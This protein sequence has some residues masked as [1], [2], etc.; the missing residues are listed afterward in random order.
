MSE[1]KWIKLSTGMFDDEKIRF[2]ETLPEADSILVIWLKLLVLAGKKNSRGEIFMSEDIPYT[3]ELLSTIFHRKINTVRLALETFSRLRMIE[4]EADK[5]IVISNW[6]K[7]QNVDGLEKIRLANAERV[8]RHR[9]KKLIGD[10]CNVTGNVTGHYNVTPPAVTVTRQK[11]KETREEEKKMERLSLPSQNS[12]SEESNGIHE[13]DAALIDNPDE[14]RELLGKLCEEAFG[15]KIRP[16]QW[17]HELDHC[18]GDAL[19]FPR[20]DLELISWAHR[21]YQ[22]DPDDEIFVTDRR[23]TGLMLRQSFPALIA[24]LAAEAQKIRGAR[25]T[26]GLGDSLHKRKEP[27]QWRELFQWLSDNPETLYLP[28]SFWKLGR[29]LQQVYH[30]NIEAFQTAQST[31]PDGWREIYEANYPY[32]Q[33][34]EFFWQLPKRQRD[35]LP[36]FREN[37]NCPS[38]V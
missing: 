20:E 36:E 31:P 38:T 10:E 25:K 17:S 37:T 19:P 1:V 33:L 24:N 30:Q 35:E 15:N 22:K 5:T 26:I 23:K 7:H 29:D 27:E 28:D 16:N 32:A 4:L 18:L 8:K 14:A 11:R 21:L 2:I 12:S 3:D 13:S 6:N 34:P 9:Q